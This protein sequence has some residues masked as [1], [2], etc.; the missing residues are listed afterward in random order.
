MVCSS[1]PYL[2]V[3]KANSADPD[4]TSRSLASNIDL[5]YFTVS[6]VLYIT[7]YQQHSDATVTRIARL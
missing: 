1:N 6:Q 7:L 3:I 5:H 4:Q 2:P